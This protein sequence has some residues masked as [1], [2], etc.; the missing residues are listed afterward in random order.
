M[1]LDDYYLDQVIEAAVIKSWSD[2]MPNGKNG[3]VHVKY[4][5]AEKRLREFSASL[6]IVA[7]AS[8]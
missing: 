3:L 2:L 7:V 8:A 1:E 5:F 6:V 4:D